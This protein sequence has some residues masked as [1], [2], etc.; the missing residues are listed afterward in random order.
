MTTSR[1]KVRKR[2]LLQKVMPMEEVQLKGRFS[3]LTRAIPEFTSVGSCCSTDKREKVSSSAKKS[4]SE[5]F[6]ELS[7]SRGQESRVEIRKN[8]CSA[9]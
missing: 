4:S 3:F 1:F 8:I 5:V 6:I 2:T 7:E 9:A